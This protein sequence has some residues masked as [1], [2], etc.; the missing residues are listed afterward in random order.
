[1]NGVEY[2]PL[3]HTTYLDERALVGLDVGLGTRVVNGKPRKLAPVLPRTNESLH[4]QDSAVCL[5]APWPPHVAHKVA[6][7]AD[8][9]YAC[10]VASAH[11]TKLLW[12]DRG[13]GVASPVHCA[14]ILSCTGVQ[15]AVV[16][17]AGC[18]A[19]RPAAF[20]GIKVLAE[21]WHRNVVG[22]GIVAV[23]HGTPMPL[24]YTVLRICRVKLGLM[25]ASTMLRCHCGWYATNTK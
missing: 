3:Q 10:R 13:A 20:L 16:H 9:L 25:T 12:L 8:A 19:T 23:P 22:Q 18:P 14:A 24:Q 7:A 1:M 11:I 6:L 5:Y 17:V 2:S 15:K 4:N 21:Q